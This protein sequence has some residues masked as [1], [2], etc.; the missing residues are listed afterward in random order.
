M[1][2]GFAAALLAFGAVTT[3]V[4]DVVGCLFAA[5]GVVFEGYVLWRA[6]R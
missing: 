6:G 1:P 4:S 3:T 2:T 5:T